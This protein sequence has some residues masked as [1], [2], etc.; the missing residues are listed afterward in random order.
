MDREYNNPNEPNASKLIESLRYLGYDNY[1]ALAD[2]LDNSLDAEATNIYVKIWSEKHQMKIMVADD[3]GGMDA[4]VLDQALRL[5][6]ITEK[7][8]VSDLG[9][10]GMGL[11][12]A[13]LSLARRTTVITKQND[14]FLTSIVDI[15]RVVE[16]NSF[17]KFIGESAEE[18]VKL[19][20]EILPG[21]SSGTVVLFDK[22]DAVKNQNVSVFASTLR[23]HL[24]RIHRYF[25]RAGK[26][27]FVNGEQA[28][29]VDP[30][31]LDNQETEIYS[32]DEY[33]VT[34]KENGTDRAVKIRVRIVLIPENRAGGERQ[35]ALGI[36]NQG[37]YVLRNNRE[38]R[39]ADTLDA[40]TKHNDFNRMRGEVFLSGRLDELVGIDFTKREIVLDQSFKDQLLGY[41]RPQCTSIKRQERGRNKVK[42]N[43][44]VEGLHLEAQKYIDEKAKLLILPKTEVE[45][46]HLIRHVTAEE[47][48]AEL[49]P[50][51]TRGGFRETQPAQ[52]SRCKFEY[53]SLGPNGQIYECD[54]VGRTVVIKWNIDHPFYQ[55]FVLDQRS[56]GRLVTAIDYLIYSLSSAELTAMSED[57]MDL[58]TGFKAIVSSNVRTLLS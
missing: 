24:G 57:N 12:T 31:E 19:F 53:A 48:K 9:K 6:S 32:D 3:G 8:P 56:D 15:D 22:C 7:D 18:D 38:I 34:V 4:Q 36:K 17:C 49:P 10:F 44:E 2:I 21:A 30:L 40:F 27:I 11:V 42:E 14:V 46:R 25:I 1:V 52:A 29:I 41:L 54:L 28:P 13:G 51:R 47:K 39:A 37:F 50:E 35:V 16:T 26:N 58:L 55:R 45:K 5:G 23:K 20:T 43:P 33:P